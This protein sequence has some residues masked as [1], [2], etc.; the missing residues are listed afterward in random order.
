M[1]IKVVIADYLRDSRRL[2][3]PSFGAFIVKAP[4]EILFSE[5]LKDDDGVLR[6]LLE[7]KGLGEMECA[8][9]ID[10]FI[11]EARHSL[12]TTGRFDMGE[13]GSLVT[14]LE[15]NIRMAGTSAHAGIHAGNGVQRAT[16]QA[17]PS[18][19]AEKASEGPAPELSDK[20]QRYAT[21]VPQREQ[22]RSRG[23]RGDGF[24]I[25]IA[26]VVLLAAIGVIAYGYWCSRETDDE[27]AMDALRWNIEQPA[28]E[29]QQ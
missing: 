12:S 6:R 11:F 21:A 16:A 3:V 5:L 19:T 29:Q 8:G 4:G 24:F 28:S 13:M 26:I 1:D 2:V 20:G 9:A 17:A 25:F 7:A 14:D 18:A 10:R 27:A 15:G 22:R 23:R